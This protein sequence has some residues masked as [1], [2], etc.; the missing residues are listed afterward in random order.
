MQQIIHADSYYRCWCSLD[1]TERN[2][3]FSIAIFLLSAIDIES[4]TIVW[5]TKNVQ[6]VRHMTIELLGKLRT[7]HKRKWKKNSAEENKKRRNENC[8][9]RCRSWKVN[10]S[11]VLFTQTELCDSI[12]RSYFAC[13]KRN[14]RSFISLSDRVKVI[15]FVRNR[16]GKTHLLAAAHKLKRSLWSCIFKYKINCL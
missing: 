10:S 2:N 16:K 11:V 6:H 4:Y 3:F 5:D 8:I 9:E 14:F 7:E 12:F 13:S 15:I 1:Y